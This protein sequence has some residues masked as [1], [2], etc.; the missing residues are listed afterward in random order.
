MCHNDVCIKCECEK[1]QPEEV[2]PWQDSGVEM[3]F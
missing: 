1:C 3:G 2:W